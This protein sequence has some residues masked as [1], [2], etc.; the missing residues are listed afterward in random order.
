MKKLATFS[1]LMAGLVFASG[2]IAATTTIC[3]PS[4]TAGAASTVVVPTNGT[5]GSTYMLRAIAPKCSA[6]T[7][8][9]GIDGA[10]GAWYAIGSNSSKGKASFRGHSNGGIIGAGANCAI[11]GGCTSGEAETARDAAN[12]AA[13]TT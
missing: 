5:V 8:V 3:A 6:N 11:A 9:T 4:T 10:N 1:A 13:A 12:T 7:H 2:A